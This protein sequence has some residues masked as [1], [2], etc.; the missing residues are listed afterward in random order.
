MA[1]N[2]KRPYRQLL[3]EIAV[4]KQKLAA[5]EEA[6]ST[7]GSNPAKETG[8][9]VMDDGELFKS[10]VWVEKMKERRARRTTSKLRRN[11]VRV[12]DKYL[13]TIFDSAPVGISVA[14]DP[15]C[16]VIWHNCAAARFLRIEPGESPSFLAL[17]KPRFKMLYQGKELLPEEMPL[18]RAAWRGETSKNLELEYIWDDEVRK[19]A[20]WN[21]SPLISEDGGIIGAIG[22]LED[23][24]ERKQAEEELRKS[25]QQIDEILESISD[26]FY[27]VDA[28]WRLTYINHRAEEWWK[29]RKE[30]LIGTVLW[31]MFPD[32]E[33]TKGYQEHHRAMN[34]HIPVTFETFLPHFLA[35][36]EAT[37]YPT[38]DGGVSVYLQ[39]ITGRKKAEEVL[40]EN[41][42]RLEE[43]V[44]ERTRELE[45][46][47]QRI[48]HILESIKDPFFTLDGQWR[49][50]YVNPSAQE[51]FSYLGDMVGQNIWELFPK[52][53]GTFFWD[54]YHTVMESK[55]PLC[56][57][58]KTRYT[59]FWSEVTVYPY[60][61][62]ISVLFQDITERK[63]AEQALQ[64]NEERLR[65]LVTASS[66][67]L[68]Q[69]SPDWSMMRQLQ[70]RGFL[71]YTERPN[72][73][74]LQEY[75][76]PDEQPYVTAA[77][78]EAIH[79]KSVFELEHRVW[80][81]DGSLGWTFSRAI[82]LLDEK[83]EIVEWF[84]AA[85]DITERRRAQKDLLESRQKFAKAFYGNPIMMVLVTI[86]E[87]R[88]LDCNDT[89]CS[90]TG[91][92]RDEV[93][94]HT[95]R[96]L[97]LFVDLEKRREN[98]SKLLKTGRQE[99]VEIDIRTKSGKILNCH[100]W[101][102]LLY[103]DGKPCHITGLI[104]VTKQKQ[105]EKEISHLD[106]L[107]L[108]GE[109]AASIGHEI[110]NPMT[111]IRGFLQ[112]LSTKEGCEPYQ[113]YYDL[114]IEELDRANTIITEYLNM[115]KDKAVELQPRYLDSIVRAIHPMIL[116]DANLQDKQV[117]LDLD[118]PPKLIIDE[119]EI[120]QMVLNLARN[121]LE[122][123]NQGGVLTIRTRT[124]DGAAVL[125][126]E[127]KGNGIPPKIL[128]RI[129]TP[130]QTTKD[131]GTGLGLPVC[132]SIAARHR[133]KIEV[134]TGPG[135]TTFKVI[136][137]QNGIGVQ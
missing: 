97:N 16:Q 18:K 70:S 127:D 46:A 63:R 96:E 87:G 36:V 35:W 110:R 23:V 7:V 133:A 137:K 3:A 55:R 136:F 61:E 116:A 22:A 86:D 19:F 48:T 15:S 44:R 17:T 58:A 30:D 119:K 72:S 78:N 102:Q 68:Y 43:L 101:S 109:M 74:W 100:M 121:G 71:T 104:D 25:K 126:V 10:P 128:E 89:F 130:F 85:G 113:D 80:Q 52:M 54:K 114:M 69:M 8:A 75:I 31:D 83:G 88:N 32:P 66:E 92:T 84:G 53:A 108:V 123:M 134:D 95:S 24:T 81:A 131:N 28:E 42:L 20:R 93:V 65:A 47:N 135:G 125:E 62:G 77:I 26:A 4:L 111:T 82:P 33:V 67:V 49:F 122:A 124:Y 6:A 27:A 76:P 60:R 117:R 9:P 11:Q 91:Y 14:T 112:M 118:F 39:D 59:G 94:G 106:R 50:T 40:L 1:R 2:A 45:A 29:R 107:N 51:Q 132:Y 56:F 34:E 99:N 12:P 120:R 103:L 41:E 64:K 13:R 90:T 38:A 129:G 5:Y 57:E 98:I 37:V 105:M 73:N 115:A 79:T 21:A